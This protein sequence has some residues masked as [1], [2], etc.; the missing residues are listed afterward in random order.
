MSVI[1]YHNLGLEISRLHQLFAFV[2][3]RGHMPRLNDV[4]EHNE[5]PW[6]IGQWCLKKMEWMH[7]HPK[8][9]FRFEI[10]RHPVVAN[11]LAT[12]KQSHRS[13]YLQHLVIFTCFLSQ[14]GYLPSRGEIYRGYNIGAWFAKQLDKIRANPGCP[15]H[16]ALDFLLQLDTPCK[17]RGIYKEKNLAKLICFLEKHHRPPLPHEELGEWYHSLRDKVASDPLHEFRVA[18]QSHQ[19][20][21]RDLA[22]P[23]PDEPARVFWDFVDEKL[24]TPSAKCFFRNQHIGTWYSIRKEELLLWRSEHL[25]TYLS[26][27]PVV[28]MDIDSFL[29]VRQPDKQRRCRILLRFMDQHRRLPHRHEKT[30]QWGIGEWYHSWRQRRDDMKNPLYRRA[31][32]HPLVQQDIAAYH[33]QRISFKVLPPEPLVFAGLPPRCER[34]PLIIISHNPQAYPRA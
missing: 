33:K 19:I 20:L 23:H 26:R 17:S 16:C 32:E 18:F 21:A 10:N 2:D 28:K 14:H 9:P 11:Y 4:V 24:T 29:A 7:R 3:S 8:N 15:E 6:L 12:L 5:Q 31:R 25:Y 1:K 34:R 22:R 27:H 30:A 13:R